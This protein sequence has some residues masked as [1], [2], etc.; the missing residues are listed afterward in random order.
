MFSTLHAGSRLLIDI[1]RVAGAG[2]GGWNCSS[3]RKKFR[4][5]MGDIS[6]YFK[7]EIL[8]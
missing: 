3:P 1:I 4:V 6:I 2:G 5:G 7:K 8:I